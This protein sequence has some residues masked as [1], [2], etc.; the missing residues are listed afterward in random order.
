MID[1]GEF[2]VYSFIYQK[3]SPLQSLMAANHIGSLPMLVPAVF[4]DKEFVHSTMDI[5]HSLSHYS[6][7]Y[8]RTVQ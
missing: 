2:W 6:T 8:L 1:K 4:S 7:S 3:V 5:Y